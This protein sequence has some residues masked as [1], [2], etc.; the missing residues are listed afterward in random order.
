[1]AAKKKKI[2]SVRQ[3]IQAEPKPRLEEAPEALRYFLLK[4][5]E[6]FHAGRPKDV[7]ADF[8][9]RP[10]LTSN[11]NF[12]EQYNPSDVYRHIQSFDWWQVYELAEYI[13]SRI[14]SLHS[15]QGFLHELNK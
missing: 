14:E 10:E 8:L 4:Y 1:M 2:F 9:R 3:G 11:W 6:T 7:L 5:L 13:Y 12:F 15:R